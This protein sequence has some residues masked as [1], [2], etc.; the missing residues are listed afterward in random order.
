MYICKDFFFKVTKL[1]CIIIG[2]NQNYIWNFYYMKMAP[3]TFE[4]I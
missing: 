4:Q 2:T 3:F 1:I